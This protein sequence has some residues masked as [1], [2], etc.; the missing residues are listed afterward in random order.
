MLEQERLLI[1]NQANEREAALKKWTMKNIRDNYDDFERLMGAKM[2]EV[3]A[4]IAV[5]GGG[6]GAVGASAAGGDPK[7]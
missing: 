5:G 3:K 6:S 7:V 2:N 4:L 1:Q